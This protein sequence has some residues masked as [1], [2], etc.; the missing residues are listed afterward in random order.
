M[1]LEYIKNLHYY[2]TESKIHISEIKQ[3]YNYN[4]ENII[5]QKIIYC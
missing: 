1:F 5:S 4:K 2:S 3:L